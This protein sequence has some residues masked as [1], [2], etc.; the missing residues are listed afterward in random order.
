MRK[1]TDR[2][3]RGEGGR[4]RGGGGGARG[5]C[6][7]SVARDETR[8]KMDIMALYS[9]TK[10]FKDI[11]SRDILKLYIHIY[12]VSKSLSMICV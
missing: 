5:F 8:F 7:L 1:S 6:R 3:R 2:R 11:I 12:R 4:R 9:F 10:E